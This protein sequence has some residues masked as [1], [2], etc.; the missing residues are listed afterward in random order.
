MFLNLLPQGIKETIKI[1]RLAEN[2]KNIFWAI[3][4]ILIIGAIILFLINNELKNN[5]KNYQ[6]GFFLQKN[7]QS[8]QEEDSASINE[9]LKLKTEMQENYFPLSAL[10]KQSM[11]KE[12]ENLRLARIKIDK[13][14]NEII[15]GGQAKNRSALIDFKKWLENSSQ[16]YNINFPVENIS[17]KENIDFNITANLNRD[18]IK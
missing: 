5:L 17:N 2:I 1:R 7:Y 10:L 8:G 13:E 16:F 9:A 15:F 11:A 6:E 3:F 4:A 12:N 14:K 18:A